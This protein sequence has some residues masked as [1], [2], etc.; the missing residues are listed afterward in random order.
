M[1]KAT[2]DVYVHGKDKGKFPSTLRMMRENALK[3]AGD[4]NEHLFH[5][6]TIDLDIY[7]L[8]DGS[9]QSVVFRFINPL[10]AW[11][12]AANK[13]VMEGQQMY[14]LPKAMFHEETNERLYGAGVSFGDK[15]RLAASR[16]PTGGKPA[17]FGIS[18]DGGDSGVSNRSVYPICVSVLNFDGANPL[19]C[20]LVGFIP[21]IDVPKSFRET[22]RY[23]MAR[24]CVL[25]RCIGA[26]IDEIEVV[27][28]HGF[29]AI[30][31][32]KLLR[33]HPFL[34]A[35][36]VDTKERKAYFGLRSDRACVICRCRKGWSLMRR[37][38]PHSNTQIQ[39]LWTIGIDAPK[40]RRRSELHR[41][42]RRARERLHRHG[43]HMQYRY[44]LKHICLTIYYDQYMNSN[45]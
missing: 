45:I 14:F 26:I 16:T 32:A 5:E 6:I 18:F 4:F 19:S 30:I 23:R 37:G 43:F 33:F 39:R 34:A 27:A 13:M 10:W 2:R 44:M 38:T 11:V 36:R 28:R 35:V 8:P 40:A 1:L 21:A 3:D 7:D 20:G 22:D 25:Q 42:Q 29:T 12:M 17:L 9:A 41:A 15:L 31:G 24:A